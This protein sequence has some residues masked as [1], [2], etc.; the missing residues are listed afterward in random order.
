MYRFQKYLRNLLK[1]KVFKKYFIKKD[2][3]KKQATFWKK[4]VFYHNGLEMTRGLCFTNVSTNK[5]IF[6]F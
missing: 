5:S 6:N 3:Y 2:F 1:K 4:S